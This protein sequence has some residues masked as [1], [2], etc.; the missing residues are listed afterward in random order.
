MALIQRSHAGRLDLI[1]QRPLIVDAKLSTLNTAGRQ[2]PHPFTFRPRRGQEIGAPER[3]RTSDPQ[4][5]DLTACAEVLAHE[6]G[7]SIGERPG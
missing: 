4:I 1:V 5:R 6:T 7:Q 3:I 2:Y